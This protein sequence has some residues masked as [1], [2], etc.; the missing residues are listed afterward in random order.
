[1]ELFGEVLKG[2]KEYLEW[3]KA[4]EEAASMIRA[5]SAREDER[6]LYKGLAQ[7]INPQRRVDTSAGVVVVTDRF[8]Y[9]AK[10]KYIPFVKTTERINL[11]IKSLKDVEGT[12]YGLAGGPSVQF[13][14]NSDRYIFL[15]KNMVSFSTME[16][17]VE[18]A[19]IIRQ[20]QA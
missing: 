9:L 6:V 8:V 7:Y 19:R 15:L 3:S 17:A 14:T 2:F 10:K 1:M 18:V 5:L 16:Q 4:P 13:Q 20:A 11:P 12:K